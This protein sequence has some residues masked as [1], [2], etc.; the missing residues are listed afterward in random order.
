MTNRRSLSLAAALLCLA[1][2]A[3]AGWLWHTL[4]ETRYEA[5]AR[6]TCGS[7]LTAEED[8]SDDDEAL[9]TAEELVLSPE[10]LSNAAALLH[11]RTISLTLASPFDSETDYLLNRT[12][13][14]R[15]VQGGANEIQITCDAANADEAREMLTAVVDAF[16]ES[17]KATCQAVGGTAAGESE[18]ERR[19]LARAIQR[20]EAAVADLAE[21]L[22]SAGDSAGGGLD[23]AALETAAALARLKVTEAERRLD[24]AQRHFE[25]KT[26]AEVV[27]AHL[28]EGPLKTGILERLNF[29]KLREELQGE[30]SRLKKSSEV[31]G[32]NHPRIAEIRGK[33]EQLRREMARSPQG[34]A[35]NPQ[36]AADSS[37][38]LIVLDALE[39]D[40]ADAEA[41]RQDCEARLAAVRD[42]LTA[43]HEIEVKLTD[44]RQELAFLRSED[45]GLRQQVLDVRRDEEEKLPAVLEEPALSPDP[46]AP[47]AGLPIAV[48]CV[49]GMALYLLL[50][51]QMRPRREA[52]ASAAREALPAASCRPRFFSQEEQQLARLKM[53]SAAR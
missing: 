34:S 8:G 35:E 30:E 42:R 46:V 10:V 31:Y 20:Q 9:S 12:H 22:H 3:S 24:D 49:A 14:E 4:S 39:S 38:L 15:P 13:V 45:E 26:P 28:P 53:L 43:Q 7:A 33:I 18:G 25:Q 51:W 23:P 21:Q 52:Q 5:R 32:R 27:A 1:V 6:L 29:V 40:L 17:R 50:L 47:R 44:A 48:S 16:A 2:S 19:Q 37:L 36:A 41:A 11:D